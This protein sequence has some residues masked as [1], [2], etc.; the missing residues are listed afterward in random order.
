MRSRRPPHKRRVPP[1]GYHAPMA[2]IPTATIES[3]LARLF[4]APDAEGPPPGLRAE[5]R[6]KAREVAGLLEELARIGR[7]E[8]VVEAAAGHGYVGLLGAELLGI[9]RLV[10][11]EREPARA[12]RCLAVARRMARAPALDVRLGDVADPALWPARP[13][14]VLA[15][16][17]CGPAADAILDRAI[18]AEARWLLLAPCCYAA[19][20]PFAA[21]A[22]EHAAALSASRHAAVRRRIVEA[23]VDA[24]RA[25]RLEAAGYE[26]VIAPF[27]PASASP[28]NLLLRARRVGEPRRAAEAAAALERLR[29]P[30]G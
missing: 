26:V 5:D 6:K 2:R 1:L 3:L 27:A 11:I 12:E 8:L 14:V 13:D 30:A 17:A 21:R 29:G 18:A 16:H 7:R 9:A 23:L 4:I 15:L 10:V 22:E 19:R 24:E 20:V 28:H 25:L